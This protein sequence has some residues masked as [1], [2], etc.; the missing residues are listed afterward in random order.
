MKIYCCGWCHNTRAHHWITTEGQSTAAEIGQAGKWDVFISWVPFLFPRAAR[1]NT[2]GFYLLLQ[3][4]DA[5]SL[6]GILVPVRPRS[7]TILLS[8]SMT[9]SLTFVTPIKSPQVK[10]FN[11]E[12]FMCYYLGAGEV[13]PLWVLHVTYTKPM[14]LRKIYL[15][16]CLRWA[17]PKRPKITENEN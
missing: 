6:L 3:I 7:L 14:E 12:R 16:V 11:M 15:S 9:S 2:L 1:C 8:S 10:G 5:H 4:L 13:N 17:V